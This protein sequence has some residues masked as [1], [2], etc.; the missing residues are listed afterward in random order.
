MINYLGY[1][2]QFFLREA[3]AG[4]WREY[5]SSRGIGIDDADRLGTF[6]NHASE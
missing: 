5:L 2:E 1:L 6:V 4:C 3:L